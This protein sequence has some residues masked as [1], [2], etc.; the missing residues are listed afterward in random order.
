MAV[1]QQFGLL[2]T[3]HTQRAQVALTL[4]E[5]LMVGGM[6]ARGHAIVASKGPDPP[7]WRYEGDSKVC[8]C[9]ILS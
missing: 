8:C 3:V 9:S 2:V 7:D 6:A 5:M 1:L 4:Y